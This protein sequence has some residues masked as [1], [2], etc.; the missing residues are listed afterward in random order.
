MAASAANA[1][2]FV[3][4]TLSEVTRRTR[5]AVLIRTFPRRV[6][7]DRVLTLGVSHVLASAVRSCRMPARPYAVRGFSSLTA[8]LLNSSEWF[9]TSAAGRTYVNIVGKPL[10]TAPFIAVQGSSAATL[11]PGQTRA[12]KPCPHPVPREPS[13]LGSSANVA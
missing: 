2:G 4:T 9:G 12:P 8:V 3:L 6:T 10:N 1:S 7:S 11:D 13:T 5:T